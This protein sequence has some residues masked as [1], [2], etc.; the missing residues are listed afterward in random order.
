MKLCSVPTSTRGCCAVVPCRFKAGTSETVTETVPA[1][2]AAPAITV[3]GASTPSAGCQPRPDC[4]AAEIGPGINEVSFTNS[5]P[6]Q[7][8]QLETTFSNLDIVNYSLV[9]QTAVTGTQSYMTYRADLLNTGTTTMGPITASLTSLDPSSAR[10]MGQGALNFAP[11]PANSQ[12]ASS[13][14]FTVLTN[15]TVP[16]DFSKL[17]WTYQSTRSISTGR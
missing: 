15:P 13:S 7:S 17:S 16:L 2:Y 6:G 3:N 12:V 5:V 10:V 9:R 8:Q 14:T 11:A 1:G 4:V